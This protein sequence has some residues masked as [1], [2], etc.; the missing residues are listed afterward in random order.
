L[1][2][3][4]RGTQ[5][6]L[7]KR[8][9]EAGEVLESVTVA[10]SSDVWYKVRF[11][12]GTRPVP[13]AS[14]VTAEIPKTPLEQ[15]AAGVVGGPS[16]LRLLRTTLRLNER[17]LTDHLR[18]LRAARLTHLPFQYKPLLKLIESETCCRST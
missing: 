6:R 1:P 7:R 16:E 5:V 17:N 10:G 14:L 15:L 8:P 4:T 18:S 11:A 13:A 9:A 12:N 3:I 2:E